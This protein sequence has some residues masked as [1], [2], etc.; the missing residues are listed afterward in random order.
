V[1]ARIFFVEGYP[2]T[3]SANGVKVQ[4]GRLRVMAMEWMA[5]G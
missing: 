3:E 5:E 1:P 2:V 4:R